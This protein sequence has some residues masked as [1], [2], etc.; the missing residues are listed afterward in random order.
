MSHMR[1]SLSIGG[2]L[3]TGALGEFFAV[4]VVEEPDVLPEFEPLPLDISTRHTVF[5]PST[6]QMKLVRP[7]FVFTPTTLPFVVQAAPC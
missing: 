5:L 4:V 1:P 2:W 7:D 3:S 6:L